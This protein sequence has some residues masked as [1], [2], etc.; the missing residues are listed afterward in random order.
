MEQ[1][2]SSILQVDTFTQVLNISEGGNVRSYQIAGLGARVLAGLYDQLLKAVLQVA[3][4]MFFFQRGNSSLEAFGLAFLIVLGVEVVYSLFFEWLTGGQTPGKNVFDLR[5]VSQSGARASARQF[6]IRNAMRA[7]DWL[8]ALYALGFARALASPLA[9]RW[10]D[11]AANTIVIYAIPLR[12]RLLRA[13]IGEQVYSTSP[14]AYLLES[15][16]L[17]FEFFDQQT[18]L[19]MAKALGRYFYKR[20]SAPDAYTDAAYKRGDYQEYLFRLFLHE[21]GRTLP[22]PPSSSL[23]E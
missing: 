16:C 18:K 10:G 15:F 12:D 17:R 1:H 7:F 20:Y 11:L 23:G 4:L 8:P 19:P 2:P 13:N 14:D 22:E 21:T 6:L 9:L 5:V 3:L